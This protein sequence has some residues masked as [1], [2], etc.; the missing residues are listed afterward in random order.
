MELALWNRVDA[1]QSELD[2]ARARLT[3]AERELQDERAL[4]DALRRELDDRSA[5]TQIGS[6]RDSVLV[7]DEE[8][9][10]D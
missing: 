7:A 5:F 1:L 3:A 6:A 8:L 4:S 2:Q 9:P 10:L